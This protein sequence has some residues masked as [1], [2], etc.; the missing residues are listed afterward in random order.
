MYYRKGEGYLITDSNPELPE[1]LPLEELN[2]LMSKRLAIK[3][4]TMRF[5]FYNAP[6]RILVLIY[7]VHAII[8]LVYEQVVSLRSISGA[9]ADH[10]HDIVQQTEQAG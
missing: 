1:G 9:A 4:A 2:S 3:G 5:I 7:A 10:V 6:V 8:E